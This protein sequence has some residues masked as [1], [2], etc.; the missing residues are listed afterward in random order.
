MKYAAFLMG[1]L[2]SMLPHFE[3]GA[4]IPKTQD[5]YYQTGSGI[6]HK[7]ILLVDV[8]VYEATHEMKVIPDP[9]TRQNLILAEVE[10]RTTITLLRNVKIDQILEGIREGYTMNGFTDEEVLNRFLA[11]LNEDLKEGATFR[12]KYDPKTQTTWLLTHNG[13]SSIPGREFMIATW[14]TWFQNHERPE[15]TEDLMKYLASAR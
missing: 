14:A 10:K 5:G 1:M 11:P 12:I 2:C 8:K 3:A 9:P 7:K 4:E 15:L 6:R 13:R